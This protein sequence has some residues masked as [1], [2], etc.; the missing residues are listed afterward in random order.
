[1]GADRER[2]EGK[3]GRGGGE[4]GGWR[5]TERVRDRRE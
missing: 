1:M 5:Q 2:E 3:T 4:Y